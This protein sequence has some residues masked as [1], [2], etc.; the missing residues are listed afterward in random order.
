MNRIINRLKGLLAYPHWYKNILPLNKIAKSQF[1]LMPK[2]IKNE[3]F[4]I[5]VTWI[6]SN[7]P[8]WIS[9]YEHYCNLELNQ[10][11]LFKSENN[12]ERLYSLDSLKYFL[13]GIDKYVSGYRK[14]FIITNSKIPNW[15]KIDP[16]KI[17]IVPHELIFPEGSALPNYNSI[18]I[19]T[20]I[21]RIPG[22]LEKYVYSNDD[23]LF[24]KPTNLD[25]FFFKGEIPIYSTIDTFVEQSNQSSIFATSGFH[26][27]IKLREFFNCNQMIYLD[28]AP[29]PFRKSWCQEIEKQIQREVDKIRGYRFRRSDIIGFTNAFVPNF[30]HLSGKAILSIPSINRFRDYETRDFRFFRH[31]LFLFS[32]KLGLT[33]KTFCF[34]DSKLKSEEDFKR[35]LQVLNKIY[36]KPSSFEK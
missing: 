22:L 17:E 4:D 16:L 20:C 25:D 3:Q 34:Y 1:K 9:T 21:H 30:F 5:V 32:L 28:H 26:S 36:P 24:I 27:M 11:N 7:D 6:D 14:I 23:F 35:P 13:R 18:A 12:K 29:A 31:H 8:K 10:D 15:L 2:S 19:E 33:S